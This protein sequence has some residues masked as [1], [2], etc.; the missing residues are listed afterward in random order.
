MTTKD[1]LLS[2]CPKDFHIVTDSPFLVSL[3]SREEVFI[4]KDD[5]WQNPDFQTYGA[6]FSIILDDIFGYNHSIPQAVI[7]SKE[8]TNCMG[9]GRKSISPFS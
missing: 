7:N 3:Y 9:F 5:K 8:C 1:C 4:W 2:T 6:D